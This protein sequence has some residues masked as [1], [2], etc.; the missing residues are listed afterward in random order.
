LS[1]LLI[2]IG[3]AGRV[4]AGGRVPD[5]RFADLASA[6]GREWVAYGRA[7]A[8]FLGN[9]RVR[10]A[11]NPDP[12]RPPLVMVHGLMAAPG[13]MGVL[14]QTLV[15]GGVP[16]VEQVRYRSLTGTVESA[17]RQVGRAVEAIGGPVDLL[18][19]SL[20]AVAARWYVKRQG[21]HR[22]VRRLVSLSG[23]QRGTSWHRIAPPWMARGLHPE[24]PVVRALSQGPE[25][26]PTFC[27]WCRYDQQV[28]PPSRAAIPGATP[29]TIDGSGHN[30]MLFR[31]EVAT[32]ILAILAPG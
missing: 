1:A 22:F 3:H 30:G 29:I 24:G 14:A 20:G 15:D 5:G 12:G 11:R 16:R 4:A 7:A 19:F 13:S 17:A 23:P 28:L 25:P 32:A 10:P 31:P 8:R 9:G 26:V 6:A 21:G 27:I 2:A 18:G